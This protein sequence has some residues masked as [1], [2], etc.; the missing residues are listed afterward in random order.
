MVNKIRKTHDTFKDPN[1]VVGGNIRQEISSYFLLLNVVSKLLLKTS[2]ETLTY[3]V[4][5]L[6]LCKDHLL[7]VDTWL[8]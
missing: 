4:F 1:L 7:A 2:N 3:L 5:K 6:L 8:C